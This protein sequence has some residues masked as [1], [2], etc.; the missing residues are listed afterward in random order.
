MIPDKVYQIYRINHKNRHLILGEPRKWNK[1]IKY[2]FS[3]LFNT[4]YINWIKEDDFKYAQCKVNDYIM[5]IIH[6]LGSE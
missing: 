2:L 1:C 3:L 6:C 5:I 4:H